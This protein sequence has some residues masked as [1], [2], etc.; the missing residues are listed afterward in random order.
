VIT[1]SYGN[2][3]DANAAPYISKCSVDNHG[4]DQAG[5]IL[6]HIYGA[7]APRAD[8]P[9]GRIVEFSQRDFAGD[10]TGMAE[11]GYLYVPKACKPGAKCK[12]HVA[13]HGCQ[14]GAESVGEK[15]YAHTGY[16]QWADSNHILVLYPQVNKSLLPVNPSGCWDWWGYTGADY[17]EKSGPQ[18]KAIMDMVDRLAERP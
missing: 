18:M 7:L 13:I 15:F 4:Y 14:Q 8:E 2:D 5:A 1:P 17:A 12:V 11:T 3:C 16:N 6:A 10:M 9:K